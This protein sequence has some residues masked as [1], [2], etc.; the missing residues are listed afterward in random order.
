[1]REA[2]LNVGTTIDMDR[3]SMGHSNSAYSAN[4]QLG[5]VAAGTRNSVGAFLDSL[6]RW[7]DGFGIA[8]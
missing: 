1:M 4:L 6:W 7:R 8:L 3:P 5:C 2:P